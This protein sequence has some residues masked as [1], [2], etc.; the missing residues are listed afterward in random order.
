MNSQH[1]LSILQITGDAAEVYLQNLL[2][3]DI[4]QLAHAH[5]TAAAFCSAQG[6]VQA[7]LRV[8]KIADAFFVV[9]PTELSQALVQRWKLFSLNRA[10]QLQLR[11][12]LTLSAVS[13]SAQS[14]QLQNDNLQLGAICGFNAADNIAMR[15]AQIYPATQDQFLPQ[16]L[17]LENTSALSY[18]KG[19]YIGQEIIARVHS[20]APVRRHLQSIRSE[21]L[22]N[23][24][25]NAGETLYCEEQSAA[26][27]IESAIQDDY[28]IALAVV[29]DRYQD[30][31]WQDTQGNRYRLL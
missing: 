4:T 28:V 10:I 2:T 24:L 5:W 13:S 11:P 17:G 8:A 15:F 14:A 19:C 3:A 26:T 12:D 21:R 1:S 25:L 29:Q 23:H 9:L 18:R 27:I 30:S 7:M 31:A 6:K 20:R 16:M 22:S